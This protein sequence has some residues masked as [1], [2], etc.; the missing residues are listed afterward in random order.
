MGPP[1]QAPPPRQLMISL[2]AGRV[3]G[4]QAEVESLATCSS[5]ASTTAATI[6]SAI[7][8]T[9]D[10]S[11]TPTPSPAKPS[12]STSTVSTDKAKDPGK[13]SS[14]SQGGAGGKK[15]KA[16]EDS[17]LP[18]REFTKVGPQKRPR[19]DSKSPHEQPKKQSKAG[20]SLVA[21]LCKSEGEWQSR[22]FAAE[23]DVK[24]WELRY[25]KLEKEYG[26]LRTSSESDR[27]R[28]VAAEA[29]EWARADSW[30]TRTATL[31]EE[32]ETIKAN[33]ETNAKLL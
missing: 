23:C 3:K 32:L 26:E 16:S 13:T 21:T 10:A 12:A 8:S 15:A 22:A 31:K 4:G 2:L 6:T 18:G 14:K 33:R 11:G 7:V 1:Q 17:D 9:L 29:T 20:T 27:V 24:R 19:G 5:G 25:K 28:L 30:K